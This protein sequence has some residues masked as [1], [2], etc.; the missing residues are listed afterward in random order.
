MNA[1]N[2]NRKDAFNLHE[3]SYSCGCFCRLK[4]ATHT[5]PLRS[6]VSTTLTSSQDCA[7]RLLA[8]D[9]SSCSF[10][11]LSI[12]YSHCATGMGL[13]LSVKFWRWGPLLDL[14][15]AKSL[16]TAVSSTLKVPVAA[17]GRA[18][19]TIVVAPACPL[20]ISATTPEGKP[21]RLKSK[22]GRSLTAI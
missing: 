11:A 1:N 20:G 22:L 13:T 3:K 16:A 15:G 4:N 14:G 18:V 12:R 21:E 6:V 8:V 19:R 17:L 7:P 10:F 9:S 2:T 5:S